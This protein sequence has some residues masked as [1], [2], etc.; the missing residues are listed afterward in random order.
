MPTKT[1]MVFW[2]QKI[3]EYFLGT[4]SIQVFFANQYLMNFSSFEFN[5]SSFEIINLAIKIITLLKRK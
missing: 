5:L 3:S 4:L 2:A 1:F